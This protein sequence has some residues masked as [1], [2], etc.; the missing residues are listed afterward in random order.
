MTNTPE[1]RRPPQLWEQRLTKVTSIVA[2]GMT[3]SGATS[4]AP[5]DV[6]PATGGNF[7]PSAVTPPPGAFIK[8]S[9]PT[10]VGGLQGINVLWDGLN[11]DGDLWPYDT[12][13]VEVHMATSGTAFTPGTATLKGRLA[14]PGNLFVGGLTAGTTYHF[15]LRGVDAEGNVTDPSDAAS[16]LTGLTTA[17]DYGTATIGSGAVSF[18]ARSI[19]GVTNTVGSTAPTNPLLNDVWLDSSPGTA[20]IHKIWDGSTWVT[21]A[22]G[23]ASIAAGQITA[24]QIAAGAITA[25]A[26]AADAITGKTVTGGTVTGA[27]ITGNTIT[28]GTITGSFISGGAITGGTVT[29]ALVRTASSGKRIEISS[30][31]ANS[32]DIEFY[33]SSGTKRGSIYG[34]GNYLTIDPPNGVEVLGNFYMNLSYL[35]ENLGA[36]RLGFTAGDEYGFRVP[37]T[38]EVYAY[39]I[40]ENTTASAANVRVGASAQLVKSTSTQNVKTALIPLDGELTGVDPA[41]LGSDPASVDPYDVLDVIP[42]EFQSLTPIDASAR[43]LGFIAENVATVFPWAAEWDDAGQPNSVA[44]RPILAALLQVVK[45]QQATIT[46]LRTRIEALEA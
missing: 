22:W 25:G 3:A 38:G 45:D 18:N 34:T 15:R 10:L 33:N 6:P 36:T 2:T 23:S 8:P 1:M 9:T 19:G 41:K 29:G 43:M 7:E 35:L 26:I 17:G 31:G 27:Q 11:A 13:F 14:R 46:D 39:G 20:I 40:D 32:G 37:S 5:P 44:D 24:L 42:T 30:D 12:S 21:N 16:G 4:L 28:G